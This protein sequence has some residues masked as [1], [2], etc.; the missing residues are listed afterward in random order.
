LKAYHVDKKDCAV[1]VGTFLCTFFIGISQGILVGIFLSIAFVMNASAFPHIA[2]LGQL[3]SDCGGHFR[4]VKRFPNA[5]Q[6]PRVAIVRMDA[7]LYFA[8]SSY[9]KEVVHNASLGLF[10]SSNVPIQLIVLDV[11][12]WIDIDLSGVNTLNEIHSDLLKRNIQLAIANSK[13]I[14][15]DRLKTAKF[16]EK[17]G[18]GYLFG[19]IEDAVRALNWRRSTLELE[20]KAVKSDFKD[21]QE[22]ISSQVNLKKESLDEEDNVG[23]SLDSPSNS[24][25]STINALHRM[26]QVSPTPSTAVVNPLIGYNEVPKHESP[27]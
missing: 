17:L 21:I 12:A 10:H 16:I 19:S 24:F 27:V 26:T 2:H 15:R 3:P 7:S 13:G 22:L 8:N 5:K 9:M 18:E 14:L 4:D 11:S 23:Y 20:V 25:T 6:L 1:M